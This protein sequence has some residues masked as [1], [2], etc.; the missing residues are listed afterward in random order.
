MYLAKGTLNDELT[1]EL[2]DVVKAV[3]ETGKKGSITLKLDI[4][5]F[6]RANEDAIRISPTVSKKQPEHARQ[7]TVMF[8][9][10]DGDMLRNDPDQEQ[11]DLATV[12]VV[13]KSTVQLGEK[14]S[15]LKRAS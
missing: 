5:M 10:A 14:S 1:E 8:S 6:D 7:D 9:T 11:L 3:R 2:A 15:E 4:S 13:K 12:E